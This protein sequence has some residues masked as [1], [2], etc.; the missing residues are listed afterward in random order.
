ML[1]HELRRI[2]RRVVHLYFA[3]RMPHDL[4]G[5]GPRFHLALVGRDVHLDT[6]RSLGL[7]DTTDLVPRATTSQTKE[8]M[9]TIYDC[10]EQGQ[11]RYAP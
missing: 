2:D 11:G 10:G 3:E 9:Q 8:N 6:Q 4:L 1:V 7:V 5:A